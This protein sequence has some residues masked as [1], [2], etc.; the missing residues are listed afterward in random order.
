MEKT[1]QKNQEMNCDLKKNCNLSFAHANTYEGFD[2]ISV[3]MS[4][5]RYVPI[6][7]GGF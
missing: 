4:E 3:D 7:Q 2:L 6:F 5:E 1:D